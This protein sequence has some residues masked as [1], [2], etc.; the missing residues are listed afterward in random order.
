MFLKSIVL[1]KF[2]NYPKKEFDFSKNTLIIGKNAAGKSNLIEAIGFLALGESFK[3]EKDI[4]VIRFREEIARLT[5]IVQ[6]GDE[7]IKLEVV[8]G[9]Q[10]LRSRVKRYL[11]NGVS[12]RKNDFISTFNVVIFSPQDLDIIVG[13]PSL[14]RGFFDSVLKQTD[15][16]YRI[17]HLEYIKALRQRNALLEISRESGNRNEKQFEY[18]DRLIID[19]GQKI[20]QKREELIRYINDFQKEVFDFA[21]FYDKSVISKE[22]L[23]QYE[24]A[25]L[26]SANTLVG[27]HRDDFSLSIFDDQRQTTHDIKSY[28]SRGQQ[29]MAILQLKI[30]ELNYI[31]EK[32]GFKPVLLMDDIFSELDEG[33]IEI[34][35][36]ILDQQQTITTT[37]HE[38]F[39][40]KQLSQKM[41]VVRLKE[42]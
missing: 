13:S 31:R 39:V 29:R 14:R 3:A 7:E 27:P 30:I 11:I 33:H 20:T 25:E 41:T 8:I 40:P 5:G 15:K 35:L 24:K 6:K 21:A 17:A 9:N 16:E 26:A 34:I 38:E 19:S 4:D 28:G 2:R 10:E 42:I 32:T 1:Q 12:K 23:F 36:G 18:W 37:T 22:R